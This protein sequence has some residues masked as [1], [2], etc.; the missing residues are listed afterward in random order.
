MSP[1]EY[2]PED[3]AECAVLEP[4]P[5]PPDHLMNMLREQARNIGF[6]SPSDDVPRRDCIPLNESLTLDNYQRLAATTAQYPCEAA[7]VYPALGLCGEAG[8]FAEKF[9]KA[10]FPEG[11][12]KEWDAVSCAIR[13]VYRAL[14]LAAAAG[15]E[16]ERV[17]KV[18]RDKTG[19]LPV[20]VLANLQGRFLAV[21][22]DE[23]TDGGADLVAELAD[24][25]WY[26]AVLARD[27]GQQLSDVARGN[28]AKLAGRAARGTLH[29]SGDNR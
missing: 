16:C 28:L 11:P 17:K 10:L 8:E 24:S 3:S 6:M 2:S 18:V 29:G 9:Q 21:L 15:K 20:G 12:P 23:N 13:D 14:G 27:L 26:Y 5:L 22:A 4:F 25:G 7:G 19:V 1:D